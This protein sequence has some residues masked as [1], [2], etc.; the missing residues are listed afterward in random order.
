MRHLKETDEEYGTVI[1]VQVENEV[2]VLEDSRDRSRAAQE[3]FDN[4]VPDLLARFLTD[5][6]EM[7]HPALRGN[8]DT[9]KRN[10]KDGPLHPSWPQLFGE[11]DQTDEIFMAYHYAHYVETIAAAGKKVYNLPMFTNACSQ[12]RQPRWYSFSCTRHQRYQTGGIPFRRSDRN[13]SRHLATCRQE[14][15]LCLPRLLLP[16]LREDLRQLLSS[17]AAPVHT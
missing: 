17:L 10:A 15:G 11:S 8:L 9:F 1:V 3:A 6:W 12:R 16:R 13:R 14:L 5:E 4:E 7:L 2:G